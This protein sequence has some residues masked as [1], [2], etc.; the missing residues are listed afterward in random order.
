MSE[1]ELPKTEQ[2]GDKPLWYSGRPF[3][4]LEHKS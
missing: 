1:Q 3:Q 2:V 4:M